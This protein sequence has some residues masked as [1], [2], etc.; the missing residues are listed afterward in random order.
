MVDDLIEFELISKFVCVC[1]AVS[2]AAC[3][4]YRLRRSLCSGCGNEDVLLGA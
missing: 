2:L 4:K 3:C 1:L